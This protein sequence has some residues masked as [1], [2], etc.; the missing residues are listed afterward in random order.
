MNKSRNGRVPEKLNKSKSFTSL[1]SFFQSV[2]Q[3]RIHG[4]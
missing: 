1:R 2:V 3:N 4:A